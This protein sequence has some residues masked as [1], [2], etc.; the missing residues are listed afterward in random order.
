MI[1]HSGHAISTTEGSIIL[2]SS[3]G[4]VDVMIIAI[5]LTD[6]SK[7]VLVDYGN[8][9]NRKGVWLNSIDFDD[10]IGA[11]L[12][13]FH[14]FTGNDYASSIFKRGKQGCFKAMKQCANLSMLSDCLEKI[15]S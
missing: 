2:R 9:K 15:G 13:W 5:S 1:L 3:S 4:D 12:I 11:V 10:N 7:H 8:G 14:A 6:T